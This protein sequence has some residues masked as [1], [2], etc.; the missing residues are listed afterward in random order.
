M[1]SIDAGTIVIGM[2]MIE[3]NWPALCLV[4]SNHATRALVCLES[5]RPDMALESLRLAAAAIELSS[6]VVCNLDSEPKAR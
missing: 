5:D 1:A 2:E 4:I 6:S 3:P